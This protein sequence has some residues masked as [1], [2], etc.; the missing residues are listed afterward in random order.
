VKPSPE[1]LAA[2]DT[3]CADPVNVVAHTA[4]VTLVHLGTPQAL[5][6]AQKHAERDR[7]SGLRREV[8]KARRRMAFQR[9][10]M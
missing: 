9:A 2:L 1:V 4:A 5:A 6:I 8:E 7:V 3:L 10:A